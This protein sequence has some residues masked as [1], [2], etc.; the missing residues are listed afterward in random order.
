[1]LI[2]RP[3]LILLTGA[4]T[5]FVQRVTGQDLPPEMY[6]SQDGH[7]LHIGGQPSTG[8][9]QKDIL[10]TI[11][12]QFPQPNYWSLMTSNYNSQ[13]DIPAT[14]I[15][16]GVTYD[17]VGVRFKGQ[18][19][20]SMLPPTSQ[21]K[22]FNITVNGFVAGQDI[23]GYETLNLNNAFQDASFLREVIFLELLRDHI[24]AAKANFVHLNING[25]SWGLYPN[26]QQINSEFIK[27][28]YFSNDGTLW[29][30]DRPP[31]SPGG[32]GGGWGDGT[33]ALNYL[34]ADT[35]EYQDH[36]TLK[37]TEQ[38]DPWDDLVLVCNK[39]NSVPLANLE[40]SLNRYL[41]VDRTLWF[42]ASEIAFS[43]DDS[44]VH[45]GKMDY[46]LYWEAETGRMI[47]Q[48][49]DGNSV[50]KTNATTWSP[51]Y[52]ADDVNYPLLNRMLAVPSMRQRYL[53]HLRTIIN[54]K[55]QSSAFN[56]MIAE[57]NAMI[58]A[59]VQADPKKLYTYAAYQSELTVLQN[60]ITNRRNSLMGNSEVA[61]PAPTIAAVEH[62]VN[63]VS[64]AAPFSTDAADVRATVTSNNGI[65]SVTMFY[66]AGLHGAFTRVQ[67]F[68]DGAHNDEG[69]ADGIYG[70]QIPAFAP[71]TYVR[72]Y[73]QAAANNPAL[74]VTYDPPGAE[75]DVY[76]YQVD[77]EVAV[78]PPVRI[79]ELMA[80]NTSTVMDENFEYADWIELYNGSN[81][82]YDLSGGWLSD[83]ASDLYKWQFPEGSVIN[84]DGYMT[85]WADDDGS[86]GDGHADF[87]L[88][89]SGEQVWLTSPQSIVLDQVTFGEQVADMGYARVPNGIGPFVIQEPTYGANNNLP[90]GIVEADRAIQVGLFPNPAKVLV[91][92]TTGELQE[93]VIH[94]ALARRVWEGR[95]NG[96][97]DV[98]VSAWTGG[99]YTVRCGNRTLKLVVI[100]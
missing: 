69:A 52:N 38:D 64:W 58:N 34:G 25:A 68:D 12:L 48:E 5:L 22:S 31:G 21:K 27:E 19:S 63:G 54:E 60:F 40:D 10:R 65:S 90:T 80:Q 89:A 23:M 7:K 84:P 3:A 87:K 13:T 16:D 2:P 100:N 15:V 93:V 83:D 70:A 75:H 66:S 99:T 91:T 55:M 73:I 17:S 79:N 44:Y 97:T 49:F 95:V 56:A 61:Q 28:W 96:R 88:T 86:Q 43:D 4:S 74:T 45:K 67:M 59:E 47:P 30:A 37:R 24:P 8:F 98:D 6:F 71:A 1:M 42:L 14:M 78:D 39:L 32:P 51:F 35:S 76:I 26:V 33:A 18:T 53:A 11:D 41:D 20:Y 50:M 9:Y 94:D 92:I 46:Y 62:R 36:Y 57:Y 82:A 77:F 29:R 72:Y 85:I 81:Q